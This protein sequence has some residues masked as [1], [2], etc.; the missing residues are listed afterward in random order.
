VQ[1]H[2][3]TEM[4]EVQT[5]LERAQKLQQTLTSGGATGGDSA[6]KSKTGSDTARRP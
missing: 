2:L 4:K 6:S 5:H 1:Q 3:T